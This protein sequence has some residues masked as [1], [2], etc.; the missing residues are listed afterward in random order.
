VAPP[1][2]ASYDV[3]RMTIEN[4]KFLG[5]DV[6]H[7]HLVKGLDFALLQK[8]RSEQA[9][10]DREEDDEDE[11]TKAEKK[12]AAAAEKVH[13]PTPRAASATLE[14]RNAP[15]LSTT[16]AAVSISTRWHLTSSG[17]REP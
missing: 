7:T 10:K 14:K 8:V 6:E 4:S 12:K 17:S 13:H 2:Q 16:K 15:S 1:G 11:E 3:H 5:G 9:K